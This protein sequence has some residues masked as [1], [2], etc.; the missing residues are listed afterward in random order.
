I[1]GM[2]MNK[3]PCQLLFGERWG[4][5]APDFSVLVVD[6]SVLK[7]GPEV[8]GRAAP[9]DPIRYVA[10]LRETRQVQE[11]DFGRR[12]DQ[13]VGNQPSVLAAGI[14]VV[15]NDDDLAANESLVVLG[16]PFSRAIRIGSGDETQRA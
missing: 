13:I 14:V 8:V 2:L 11:A 3:K 5:L 10:F 15:G 1:I 9:F 4:L 16:S 6:F 7:E 12:M